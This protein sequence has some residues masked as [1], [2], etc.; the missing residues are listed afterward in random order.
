[1]SDE[2]LDVLQES[3][4]HAKLDIL[5]LCHRSGAAK[6]H[7][8]GCMSAI[9]TLVA[10]Y[11]CVM[12]RDASGSYVDRFIMSKAHASIAQYAAMHQAGIL[13]DEDMA[14]PLR[15]EETFLFRHPKMNPAKGI[16]ISCGSLGMGIGY[17]VGLALTARRGRTGARV[18]A[19]VGDGECNEGSVWESAAFAG[20]Y[21]LDNLCVIVDENGL[22]LDGPTAEVLDSGSMAAK[23]SAFGFEVAEVDG[24]DIGALVDVLGSFPTG[25]PKALVARTRK[26]NGISFAEGRTEWHDGYLTDKLYQQAVIEIKSQHERE[27]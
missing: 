6:A 25:K 13:S 2:R 14:L 4:Y 11:L 16:E 22:Q 26:G 5:E 18:F 21:G 8:G 9:D 7:L 17:A 24:H 20:H 1:M 3:L 15:G 27:V 12:R 10:L 23:W 19:M